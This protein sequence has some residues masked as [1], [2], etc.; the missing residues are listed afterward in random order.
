MP[1]WL[2]P[3]LFVTGFLAILFFVASRNTRRG[4]ESVLARRPNPNRTQFLELMLVDVSEQA[5]QF[6]WDK[7]S[8][9]LKHFSPAITSHPDDL[10]TELPLDEEEFQEDW[11][12]EWTALNGMGESDL[13]EWP[14]AWPVTVRNF[15]RWL[16][17]SMH[18]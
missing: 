14:E 17:M 9:Q 3:T 11:S 7:C 12:A 2:L 6:L 13:P 15:G 5:A 18:I 16:D 1:E 10:L 8:E 4:I